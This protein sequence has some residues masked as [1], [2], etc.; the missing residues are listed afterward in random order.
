MPIVRDYIDAELAALP[1]VDVARLPGYGVDLAGLD[2]LTEWRPIVGGELL[3]QQ[4]YRRITTATGSY[5]GEPWGIDVQ[6]FVHS[7]LSDSE[8]AGRVQVELSR[9]ERLQSV[10]CVV[11]RDGSGGLR[12]ETLLVPRDLAAAGVPLTL[13]TRVDKNGVTNV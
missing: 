6:E 2:G 3:K 13:V 12:L 9:D 4:A 11:V 7:K 10:T 1:V 5:Y 8:I